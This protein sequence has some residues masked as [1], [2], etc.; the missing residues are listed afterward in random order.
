MRKSS[1]RTLYEAQQSWYDTVYFMQFK[2]VFLGDLHCRYS[3][4][5]GFNPKDAKITHFRYTPSGELEE[6]TSLSNAEIYAD[7]IKHQVEFMRIFRDG[8][9]E[10]T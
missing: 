6:L 8:T 3:A 7:S 1:I 5:F 10:K 4:K 2:D 9:M